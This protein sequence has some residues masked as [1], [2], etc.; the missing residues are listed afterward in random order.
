MMMTMTVMTSVMTDE[1]GKDDFSDELDYDDFDDE[2][3]WLLVLAHLT[4][5]ASRKANPHCMKKMTIALEV[6]LGFDYQR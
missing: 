5:P 3:I 6:K 1:R 4:D 2:H